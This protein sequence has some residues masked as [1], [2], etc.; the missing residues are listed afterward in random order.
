MKVIEKDLKNNTIAVA[1]SGGSDSMSLVTYLLNNK[2]RLN[3][4]LKVINIEHGIRG[5][6]SERDSNFVKKFCE[7]NNIE[8]FMFKV[9][10]IKLANNKGYSLEQAARI[11]RYEC[12]NKVINECKAD[13]IATAHHKSDNAET[14]IFN[15]LRGASLNGVS[16]IKYKTGNIIRPLIDTEKSDI[17]KYIA[18]N[19]IS[20]VTDSTNLD[21]DYTRNYIRHQIMPVLNKAFPTAE[22]SITRFAHLAGAD[23]DFL[24]NLA[25]KLVFIDKN[26]VKI[27]FCQER[28]LFYRAVVISLK[29]L[30]IEKDYTLKHLESVYCLQNQQSG[31][32]V[33]L[34][35]NAR[36]VND[37]NHITVYKKETIDKID[38]IPFTTGLVNFNGFNIKIDKKDEF[39][40]EKGLFF[41]LDKIPKNSV[42]R[43]RKDGDIFTKFGGGTKKLK[44]YF[45]NKK[46]LRRE[47]DNIILIANG[48]DVLLIAG[49]E[50]SDKIKVDKNTKMIYNVSII[51]GEK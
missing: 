27:E 47:R 1:L 4:Q 31:S 18:D 2:K 39:L 45:I 24:N 9:D 10:S 32:G 15:L 38:E 49:I 20:Y 13:Y 51:Q 8:C 16:G 7:N 28:P 25:K 11:L 26:A 21:T 14:I 44:D 17:E 23:N 34:I 50:I 37:Y 42:I 35:E 40:E 5:D 30:N 43:Q 41:D 48:N 36:A 22:N 33:D 46:I 3:L 29:A 12:F 6:E 19:N